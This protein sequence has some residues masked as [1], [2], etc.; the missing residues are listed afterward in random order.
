MADVIDDGNEMAELHL[1]AALK[2]RKPSRKLAP[3]GKCHYCQGEVAHPK[4]YC[5]DGCAEDHEWLL[6]RRSVNSRSE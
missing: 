5:D 4:I 1:Q 6:Q 3:T 2:N